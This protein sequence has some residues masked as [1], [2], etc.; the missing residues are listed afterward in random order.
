MLRTR[1]AYS[2]VNIKQNKNIR[3]PLVDCVW[4]PEVFGEKLLSFVY[5]KNVSAKYASN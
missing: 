1:P 4:I 5:V 3:I 2:A